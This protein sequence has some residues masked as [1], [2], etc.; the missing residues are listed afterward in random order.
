[1]TAGAF[2]SRMPSPDRFLAIAALPLGWSSDLLKRTAG[3]YPTPKRTIERRTSGQQFQDR[4]RGQGR[5]RASFR[6]TPDRKGS[7]KLC[8][9]LCAD[10]QAVCGKLVLRI[11]G[12]Q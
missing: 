7:A 5:N 3:D 11:A 10:V 9:L 4:R 12:V 1:M 6:R 8:R 2:Q